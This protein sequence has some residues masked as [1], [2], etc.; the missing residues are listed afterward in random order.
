MGPPGKLYL[1]N[2]PHA[3]ST[4]FGRAAR[5]TLCLPHA[6]VEVG[7]CAREEQEGNRK[8]DHRAPRD[9]KRVRSQ[10]FWERGNWKLVTLRRVKRV[11]RCYPRS[12]V[13]QK[14]S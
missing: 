9:P 14:T 2:A 7:G 5:K 13:G 12:Q 8:Q 1:T 4:S 11:F 10:R 3:Q 6:L